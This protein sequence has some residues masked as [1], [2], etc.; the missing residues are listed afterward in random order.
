MT[1]KEIYDLLKTLN[2]PVAYNHFLATDNVIPPFI[3]YSNADTDYLR[4]NDINYYEIPE[5]IIDLATDKKDIEKEQLVE[6]LLNA[7]NIIFDKTETYI[8]SEK[9]YQIRYFI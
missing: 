5:Y 2:M 3:T 7:N 1:E 9:I 6:N 8:S 4:A